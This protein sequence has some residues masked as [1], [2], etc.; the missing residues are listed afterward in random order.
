MASGGPVGSGSGSGSGTSSSGYCEPAAPPPAVQLHGGPGARAGGGTLPVGGASQPGPSLGDPVAAAVGPARVGGSIRPPA[1]TDSE[2]LGISNCGSQ[3]AG[4]VMLGVQAVQP[5]GCESPLAGLAVTDAQADTLLTSLREASSNIANALNA[6]NALRLQG[7]SSSGAVGTR[8]RVGV[9]EAVERLLGCLH[10]PPQA[11]TSSEGLA[12]ASAPRATPAS[13][14]TPQTNLEFAMP[15]GPLSRHGS[16]LG[17]S[18]T[19]LGT[20]L[21]TARVLTTVSS[22]SGVHHSVDIDLS[23]VVEELSTMLAQAVRAKLT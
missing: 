7:T 10:S 22:G 4:E 5:D 8:L 16:A 1:L 23:G 15:V 17:F 3:A 12:A 20:G 6:L 19:G 14:G 21:G 11:V 9:E 2:A 13:A 18:S